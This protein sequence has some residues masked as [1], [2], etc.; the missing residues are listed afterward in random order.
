[1][2]EV[3]DPDA[4][5]RQIPKKRYECVKHVNKKK[6]ATSCFLDLIADLRLYRFSPGRFIEIQSYSSRIF[7]IRRSV[8]LASELPD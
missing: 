1:M 4:R 5:E 3:G 8:C 6:K 2:D 7:E